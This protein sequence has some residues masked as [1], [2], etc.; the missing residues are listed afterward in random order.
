MNT[1][2]IEVTLL[3]TSRLEKLGI[4]YV[5]GGETSDRQWRDILGILAVQ[6]ESI[7][8]E[9]LTQTAAQ[10]GVDDLLSRA[11]EQADA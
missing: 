1:D 4:D 8:R 7:S 11:L 10:L 9:Y 6:A 5:V 2:A 3:V